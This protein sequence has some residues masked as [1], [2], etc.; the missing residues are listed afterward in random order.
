VA[1]DPF[2]LGI[3]RGARWETE[4]W[5]PSADY[6]EVTEHVLTRDGARI[7]LQASAPYAPPSVHEG[8]IV[9]VHWGIERAEILWDS[10]VRALFDLDTLRF[11]D[12]T[13]YRLSAVLRR[14][15]FERALW[16]EILST[17]GEVMP[18]LR[19]ALGSRV[20]SATDLEGLAWTIRGEER[21]QTRRFMARGT[22]D[23]DGSWIARQFGSVAPPPGYG[24]TRTE[25]DG[26]HCIELWAAEG[27]SPNLAVALSA[28]SGGTPSAQ[29]TGYV[30]TDAAATDAA[31]RRLRG[32][33][34]S[35]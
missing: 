23:E 30:E 28:P 3:G 12:D 22:S 21:R 7:R 17:L 32:V 29:L 8:R 10:G 14:D 13:R 6:P 20:F 15:P 1:D 31:V 26:H 18:G 25:R 24:I 33:L 2:D 11:A 19:P 4:A 27:L 9:G 5:R 35:A 16:I 34:A